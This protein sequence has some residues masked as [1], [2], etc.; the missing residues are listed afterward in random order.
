MFQLGLSD[1]E[2]I[3]GFVVVKLAVFLGLPTLVLILILRH[4]QREL[5]KELKQPSGGRPRAS[6][7]LTA[8]GAAIR[9]VA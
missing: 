6:C 9:L 8:N 7:T 2:L 1:T 5:V 3:L 4:H